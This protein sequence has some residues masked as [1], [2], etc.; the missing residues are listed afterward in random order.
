[1]DVSADR[2]G[3]HAGTVSAARPGGADFGRGQRPAGASLAI[4]RPSFVTAEAPEADWPAEARIVAAA[5]FPR[6]VVREAVRR[7]AASGRSVAEVLVRDRAITEDLWWQTLADHLGLAKV[8][9]IEAAPAGRD[10]DLPEPAV[11]CRARH[12]PILRGGEV[13]LAMAPRGAEI[14]RLAAMLAAEPAQRRRV[15]IAAPSLIRDALVRRYA[16]HLTGHALNSVRALGPGFSAA[17]SRGLAAVALLGGTVAMAVAAFLAGGLASYLLIAVA[18][19]SFLAVATLRHMAADALAAPRPTPPEPPADVDLPTYAVLVPLYRE[20]H[21]VGDLVAA[22]GVLDYPADRLDVVLVVEGDDMPTLAAAHAETAATAI[23]VLVV[24]PS[25]PRTKPKALNFALA[26]VDADYVAVFDA[27][28]RPARGQL[29]RAVAMFEA[30]PGLDGLQAVLGIDHAPASRNWFARQFSLEYAMLFRGILPMLAA[31]GRLFLFGGT[32]NHFRRAALVAAGGWD[33]YNVTEDADI[34]I[35]FARLGCRAGLIESWTGEEAPLTSGA[36]MRQRTRWMKGWMQ[37]WSVHMRAPRRLYR[38]LG[39]SNF[40]LLQ[41]L[42]PAQILCVL[43][44]PPSL[45]LLALALGGTIALSGERGFTEDCLTVACLFAWAW[46]WFG[47]F[48]LAHRLDRRDHVARLA[49]D[50]PTMPLYWLL[51]GLATLAAMI[52]LVLA[53]SRWTKTAHGRARRS[54]R[55]VA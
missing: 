53:P 26:T 17:G 1:M 35:R 21:V 25:R 54:G 51:G 2:K 39:A 31:D 28:D 12:V 45:V 29:K 23:R 38:E 49:I 46:G 50:V 34:A 14:D 44:L 11:L 20:A 10:L 8:P 36:W 18:L 5:G 9:A 41:V 30:N 7:A 37:T 16:A 55:P 3:S 6:F 48:R 15:V 33:P 42:I 43:A 24:P 22:L 32:S 19:P 52:D 13:A 27:E 40:L 47:S 4:R